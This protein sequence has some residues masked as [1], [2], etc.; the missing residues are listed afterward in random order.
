MV[1]TGLVIFPPSVGA[2]KDHTS[3]D[4]GYYWVSL[5]LIIIALLAVIVA[6]FL[7]IFNKHEGGSLCYG[8]NRETQ[9]LKK[10]LVL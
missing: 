3:K 5:E 10:S 1:D 4:H 7:Y 6:V 2:L 8:P 9:E